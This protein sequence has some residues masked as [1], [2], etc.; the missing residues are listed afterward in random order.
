MSFNSFEGTDL[1]KW[2]EKINIHCLLSIVQKSFTSNRLVANPS[3]QSCHSERESAF[4]LSR[5]MISKL[6]VFSNISK[7]LKLIQGISLMLKVIAPYT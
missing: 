7:P 2:M 6:Y 5:E 4:Y 1:I 3:T